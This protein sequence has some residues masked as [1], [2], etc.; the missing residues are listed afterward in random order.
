MIASLKIHFVIADSSAIL[1]RDSG[2]A[3]DDDYLLGLGSVTKVA[4][5]AGCRVSWRRCSG[6]RPALRVRRVRVQADLGCAQPR[7]AN[8][9]RVKERN[10]RWNLEECLVTGVAG[11]R[12]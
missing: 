6:C 7:I 4:P 1:S 10:P 8:P 12:V 9:G 3:S 2:G 5:A 11:C